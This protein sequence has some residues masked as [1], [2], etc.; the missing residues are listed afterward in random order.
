MFLETVKAL[1]VT[2]NSAEYIEDPVAIEG[3]VTT[4]V[5]NEPVTVQIASISDLKELGAGYVISEGISDEIISVDA[6][7]D[8]IYV[9]AK[10]PT[11]NSREVCSAGGTGFFTNPKKV[12]SDIKITSENV[13]LA[14][15]EIISDVWKQTGGV[16]CSVLFKEGKV[17]CKMSDVGRHNTLDKIIGYATLNKINCSEC[18][19]GC[20]GRQPSGMVRKCANAQIPV[21]ISKA[22]ST[23]SGINTAEI[24]GITLICFT[25][26]NRYTVYSHPERITG[27]I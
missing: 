2:G 7:D 13:S 8:N 16:H 6:E 26:G 18:Y 3:K 20:T 1:K 11:Y 25:R 14:T 9:Y 24:S 27:F 17:I 12:A 5:N 22:A 23:I 19:I 10:N 4:Y 15:E 21:I